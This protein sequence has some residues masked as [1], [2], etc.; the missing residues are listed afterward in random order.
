[1]KKEISSRVMDSQQAASAIEYG[2]LS[3]LIEHLGG[4][5]SV[6]VMPLERTVLYGSKAIIQWAIHVTTRPDL[7]SPI[8]YATF[9]AAEVKETVLGQRVVFPTQAPS[10]ETNSKE[11]ARQLQHDYLTCVLELL[12]CSSRVGQIITP[13][14]HRLPDEWVWSARSTEAR[15]AYQDGAWTLIDPSIL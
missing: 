13:A 11:Q 14:R 3:L 8:A 15:I 7:Q 10:V 9:R 1:M 4:L 2:K 12:K 5:Q 6:L